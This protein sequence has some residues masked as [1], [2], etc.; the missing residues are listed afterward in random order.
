MFL[1]FYSDSRTSVKT[2][3]CT[4]PSD[5][6]HQNVFCFFYQKINDRKVQ[7]HWINFYI[8]NLSRAATMTI[9]MELF[10]LPR[11]AAIK[12]GAFFSSIG[13]ESFGVLNHPGFI[14]TYIRKKWQKY[15]FKYVMT[16][17]C[18]KRCSSAYPWLQNLIIQVVM[19]CSK[20]RAAF[21]KSQLT[22]G[23][24]SHFLLEIEMVK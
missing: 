15:I 11:L 16:S 4:H 1:F 3:Y 22:E 14:V 2:M 19:S 9:L 21:S 24:F 18:T 7:Y 8:C 20:L 13:F 5:R 6:F 12:L 10:T 17:Y 23:F